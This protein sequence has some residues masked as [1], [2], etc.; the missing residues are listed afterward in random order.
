MIVNMKIIITSNIRIQQCILYVAHYTNNS[1]KR[2]S[3]ITRI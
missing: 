3:T 2:V 1:D